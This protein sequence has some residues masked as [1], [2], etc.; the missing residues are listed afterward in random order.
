M[1]QLA[2]LLEQTAHK[3]FQLKKCISEDKWLLHLCN[4]SNVLFSLWIFAVSIMVSEITHY[5]I[6]ERLF[7]VH[8]NLIQSSQS[9]SSQWFSHFSWKPS[10]P[11]I[12]RGQ[13]QC[14]IAFP[15][16][17]FIDLIK[18]FLV[19]WLGELS[20]SIEITLPE[21]RLVDMSHKSTNFAW[22]NYCE[23][24]GNKNPLSLVSDS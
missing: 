8:W 14:L 21:F 9:I 24:S 17:F 18:I 10:D 12:K 11:Q 23:I 4:S 2:F 16:F 22:A 13:L 1:L 3:I 19:L 7:V 6:R 20:L 15:Y 5:I